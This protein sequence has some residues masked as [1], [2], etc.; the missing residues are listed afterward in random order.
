MPDHG[1]EGVAT[2]VRGLDVGLVEDEL[3]FVRDG[4]VVAYLYYWLNLDEVFWCGVLDWFAVPGAVRV[5]ETYFEL[6]CQTAL[7]VLG[8]Q[9]LM[10]GFVL[11]IFR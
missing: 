3:L 5:A 4:E 9:L 2:A 7:P 6:L 1:W 10:R 11:V 8:L